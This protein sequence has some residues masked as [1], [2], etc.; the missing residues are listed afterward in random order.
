MLFYALCIK[1]SRNK[2]EDDKNVVKEDILPKTGYIKA[3]T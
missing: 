2:I 1:H 3:S